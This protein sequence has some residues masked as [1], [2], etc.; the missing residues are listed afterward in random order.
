[1]RANVEFTFNRR[2]GTSWVTDALHRNRLHGT[3]L[4]GSEEEPSEYRHRQVRGQDVLTRPAVRDTR[5][6]FAMIR[7]PRP[8]G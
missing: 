8:P 3:L 1:M 4:G 2:N 5:S 7:S 6:A